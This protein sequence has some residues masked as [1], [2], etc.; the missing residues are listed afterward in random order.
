VAET[1]KSPVRPEPTP[2]GSLG[3]ALT[4]AGFGEKRTATERKR[5]LPDP[6]MC[7][8]RLYKPKVGLDEVEYD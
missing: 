5:V 8:K 4:H 3:E 2:I 1:V 6:E 7:L